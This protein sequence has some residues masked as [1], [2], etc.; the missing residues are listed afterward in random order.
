MKEKRIKRR[1][2][3]VSASL[4][5][6]LLLLGAEVAKATVYPLPP[7]STQLAVGDFNGD[8]K[9]D[10][11]II[12]CLASIC[13]EANGGAVLVML[14]NGDGTFGSPQEIKLPLVY[15]DYVVVG[16][17][18]GDGKLDIAGGG[19][20]SAG[21]GKRIQIL[22]GD[23]KGGFT[24][25]A[26][27]ANSCNVYVPFLVGDFNNDKKQDIVCS[28]EFIPGLGNGKFGAQVAGG[29]GESGVAGDFNTDGIL[30]LITGVGHIY[31]G[32]G[33]GDGTFK[34]WQQI[35]HSP[36][37]V[38]STAVGDLNGDNKLD[39][40]LASYSS[41]TK[42][43]SV[44]TLLGQGNGTF[45]RGSSVV[46]YS[47]SGQGHVMIADYNGDGQPDVLLLPYVF[48]NKS[49]GKLGPGTLIPLEGGV[50]PYGE[51]AVDLNGDGKADVVLVEQGGTSGSQLE[52]VLTQ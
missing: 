44:S 23:G 19:Y 18:N 31:L 24:V 14:N 36:A 27:F 21:G 3:N 40:A 26:P 1:S 52:V 46:A 17:F 50:G 30:D 10:L 32:A 48:L 29:S 11:V 49:K 42:K 22:K 41:S 15:P 34:P 38:L 16:D 35:L 51:A 9:P 6:I 39:L 37:G 20:D 25:L 8:K 2:S 5:V 28:G 12:S 45:L 47:G 4:L 43:T 7:G 33:N 13:Y